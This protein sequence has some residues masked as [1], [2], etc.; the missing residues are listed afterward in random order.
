[1]PPTTR[2]PSGSKKLQFGW[3]E[4]LISLFLVIAAWAGI[5]LLAGGSSKPIETTENAGIQV[6]FTTPRYPDKAAY[7]QGGLDE[8]L[9]AAID[10]A[11]NSV[12]VAAFEIDL[13]RVTDALLRAHQRGVK[14]R[15]V[16]DSDYAEEQGPERMLAAQ[17]HVVFDDS[18]PFMHNKFV[19]I[20]GKQVW[21]GSWNL[22]DN[23]TYRNNNNA[24]V[25]NSKLLAANYTAEFEEMFVDSKFGAFSPDNTPYPIVDI[26]G[27]PVEN[28]FEA[29]GNTRARIIKLIEG[30]QSSLDVLAFVFTDDD[31]ASA[32]VAR[33]RAGVPVRIVVETR[34]V[35]SDGS[36]VTAFQK[37]GIDILPD[38]NPYMMHHKVIIIDNAVVITG[39]YNFSRNAAD[40]N[41]ENVLILHST[42]IAAQYAEEFGRVYGQAKA[43]Q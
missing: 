1:M 38:G 28:F 34:N 4:L 25:V 19:V 6:F 24:V 39:S 2:A 8:K 20:D 21:T 13:A 35:T 12:D 16:T 11:Q 3:K 41:D 26:A 37:A 36:D 40:Y 5:D 27:V 30:A 33:H 7:H 31:I 9:A 42:A 10:G 32:I 29:E 23:C 22:T 15:V 17:I 18:Q 43:A 14:V